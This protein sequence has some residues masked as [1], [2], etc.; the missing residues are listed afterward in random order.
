MSRIIPSPPLDGRELSSRR[1]GPAVLFQA[2]RGVEVL[3]HHR[4]LELGGLGQQVGQLLAV[5]PPRWPARPRGEGIPD[6]GRPDRQGRG[7]GGTGS[8]WLP[9]AGRSVSA[10]A[11]PAAEIR[12]LH[13]A[14]RTPIKDR[15]RITAARLLDPSSEQDCPNDERTRDAPVFP[16]RGTSAALEHRI[17]PDRPQQFARLPPPAHFTRDA[18]AGHAAWDADTDRLRDTHP[19]LTTHRVNRSGGSPS[20]VLSPGAESVG[21]PRIRN[22]A[23]QR[24]PSAPARSRGAKHRCRSSGPAARSASMS[25][26]LPNELVDHRTTGGPPPS[27]S[28]GLS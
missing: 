17:A 26:S 25:R 22:R 21:P 20:V 3:A 5:A 24:R 11:R 4:V 1:P 23:S 7:R 18:A 6:R 27:P 15:Q 16:R 8:H 2:E 9:R 28:D 12:R 13:R 14:E 10:R 19:G